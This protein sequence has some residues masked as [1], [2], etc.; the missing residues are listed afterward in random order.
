MKKPPQLKLNIHG[1]YEIH[2][3]EGRRSRRRTTG[4]KDL[5][6]AQTVLANFILSGGSRPQKPRESITV[7]VVLDA[8][9]AEHVQKKVVD[10]ERVAF[11]IRHLKETFGAIPAL[12]ITLTHVNAYTRH[13]HSG[14]IGHP[15]QNGTI[16]RELG[17]LVAALNH[18]ERHRYIPRGSSPYIPLPDA[19]PPK[20]RWITRD[21]AANLLRE[22]KRFRAKG[23]MTRM[24]RFVW[25]GLNTAARRTSILELTWDQINMDRGIIDFNQAGRKQTKKRRPIVPISDVLI[26]VLSRAKRESVSPFV[27]DHP[28][29]IKKPFNGAA[30]RAGLADVTPHTLRHTWATWAAQ[31]GVELWQIAGIL[32]DTMT[33]VEKNYAHHHPDYLRKA[34]T[35]N[36]RA[37]LQA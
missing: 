1:I 36:R 2:W 18:A 6:A 14:K 32:G 5:D 33:V 15:S 27:L 26:R 17:C 7:S 37:R 3:T 35:R 9:W 21:E 28:G 4:A 16:R 19:P 20:G 11:A 34:V 24:E 29:A 25:I 8:Y 12:R 22:S 30:G 23:R 10:Q 31:D 13:R